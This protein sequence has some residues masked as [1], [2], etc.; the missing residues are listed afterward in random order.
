MRLAHIA[1][2]VAT[3]IYTRPI[4][5]DVPISAVIR[6]VCDHA[7]YGDLSASMLDRLADMV[8]RRLNG[9]RFW[10]WRLLLQR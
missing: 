10:R 3:D 4:N 7:T 5:H 8:E 2:R 6:D 9:D 1:D